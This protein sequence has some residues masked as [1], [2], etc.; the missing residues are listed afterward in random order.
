M[1]T[2]DAEPLSSAPL[3]ER[4]RERIRQAGAITFREWMA[5]AL[6]DEREGY[7][8]RRDLA[9]WGR[10]GD[11]RTSPERS[12]LFAATCARYFASVYEQLGS[13]SGWTIL[14]AGAGAGHF[15]AGVLGTLKDDYPRVFAA[16]RY[17][18]DEASE[19]ALELTRERLAL[20]GER[21][22]C[23]RM[24]EL[25]SGLDPGIIFSN[26][27]MDALPVHRVRVR[28]G[29]LWELCV[30]T[31]EAGGFTWLEREP[32]TGRLAAYLA[33]SSAR[34]TEGQAAEVNLDLEAW[35]MSAARLLRRG[36]LVTI[37][38]GAE[39]RDLYDAEQRPEG[40]L[41]AFRQ[42]RF[43]ADPLSEPGEQDLTTTIDWTQ[44]VK[45]GEE[46][47]LRTVS[48]ERQDAFLLRAGLLEQLERLAGRAADDAEVLILR[49][50]AREMILPGGMAGS[51]Q[52][53]VQQ[54]SNTAPQRSITA[55]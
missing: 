24:A 18:V 31:D 16:T 43:V 27:L 25:E 10:Q 9:R 17:L 26:E 54:R 38:Y 51:F 20:Y 12:P 44:L 21:V 53:L 47:G 15:A 14:E 46:A 22:E 52:V 30:G 3:A 49:T 5:A 35:M 4:L 37:D 40:T 39:A 7:Y 11:Y 55:P 2:P 6:Y 13:P 41:R 33:R 8:A 34:L 36:Y 1:S 28:D 23:V 32:G 48:L 42:H 45:L 29:R 50:G 19:W